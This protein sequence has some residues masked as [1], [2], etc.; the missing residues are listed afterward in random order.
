ML[1]GWFVFFAPCHVCPH[2]VV[3]DFLRLQPLISK[4]PDHAKN[5]NRESNKKGLG[6]GRA[7][8]P[9]GGEGP[10]TGLLY[11]LGAASRAEG[12]TKGRNLILPM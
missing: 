5:N 4:C 10:S 9:S 6:E 8:E 2:M 12:E 3:F 1:C 7:E 11:R